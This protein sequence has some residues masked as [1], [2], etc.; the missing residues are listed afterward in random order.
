MSSL[1]DQ[2]L[3]SGLVSKKQA[4]QSQHKRRVEKTEK[5]GAALEAEKAAQTA[6]VAAQRAEQRAADKAREASRN[7]GKDAQ[8]LQ[9]RVAQIVSGGRARVD[10]R[11]NRRFYFETRDARVVYLALSE[12]QNTDLAEG[13]MGIV[14]SRAGK[15]TVVDRDTAQRVAELDSDWIRRFNGR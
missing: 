8:D 4:R 7:V 10:D 11:G 1:R 3:K 12:Q 5:G 6:A 9:N 13:R 2:L 15:V 14:E